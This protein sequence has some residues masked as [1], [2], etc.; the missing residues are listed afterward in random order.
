MDLGAI[1]DEI[2]DELP[3]FRDVGGPEH[4]DAVRFEGGRG[5]LHAGVIGASWQIDG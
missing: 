4:G 2:Q 3:G 5:P 1:G